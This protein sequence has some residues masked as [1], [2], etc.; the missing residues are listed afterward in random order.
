[1]RAGYLTDRLPY[2]FRNE[3]GKLVGFDIE[4]AYDLAGVLGVKLEFVPIERERLETQV[5]AGDCDVLMC[6]I[7]LTPDRASRMNL[8]IT[9]RVETVALVVPGFRRK[10]FGSRVEIQARTGLRVGILGNE[11][12]T[13]KVRQALPHVEWV[14][15][16]SPR[17][18][19]EETKPGLDAFLF[20]AESGSAWTLM[21]PRY[22]VIVPQPGLVSVPLVYA[23]PRG[24]QELTDYVN[25][26]IELKQK[27]GTTGRLYDYWILGRGAVEKQ[28]RWS[29]IRDVLHWAK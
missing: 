2:A 20:T 25:A 22:T 3:Q 18:F 19:F 9:Y 10:E 12:Y 11:Y 5:N 16:S 6:G 1:M 27:D 15:L 23:L 24:D 13:A 17:E 7:A 29:F 26:W 14:A 28:P 21:Y 4:M 8:S